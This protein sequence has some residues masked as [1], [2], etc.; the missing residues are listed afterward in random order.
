MWSK[1]LLGALV[2]V[3]LAAC[4]PRTVT[5]ELRGVHALHD[6]LKAYEYSIV[7]RNKCHEGRWLIISDS[8]GERLVE[9][10]PASVVHFRKYHEGSATTLLITAGSVRDRT[11][12]HAYWIPKETTFEMP[13]YHVNTVTGRCVLDVWI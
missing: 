1:L 7:Y 5:V 10:C 2:H 6:P 13:S 8:V 3:C 4:A 12:F 11:G 9:E